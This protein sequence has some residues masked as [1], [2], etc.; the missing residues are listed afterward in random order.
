MTGERSPIWR[1]V[2][3]SAR[4][5]F[6]GVLALLFWWLLADRLSVPAWQVSALPAVMAGFALGLMNRAGGWIQ[7][8]AFALGLCSCLAGEYFEQRTLLRRAA[9]R[10]NEST[11]EADVLRA[12]ADHGEA[13]GEPPRPASAVRSIDYRLVMRKTYERRSAEPG[14]LLASAVISSLM[15]WQASRLAGRRSLVADSGVTA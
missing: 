13:V 1:G 12:I 8:S 6:G 4:V 2:F 3:L 10:M 5:L 14:P 15:S 9:E 11:V 7:G